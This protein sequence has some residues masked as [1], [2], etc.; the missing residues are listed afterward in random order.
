[1]LQN[2]EQEENRNESSKNI[3]I[4]CEGEGESLSSSILD[5]PNQNSRP[6][7]MVFKK[8][9]TIIPA[10][11]V[12]EAISTLH[13]LDLRWSGPI[14]PTEMQYVQQYIF[15]KYPEYNNGLVEDQTEKLDL[16]NLCIT[17]GSPESISDDH[18]RKSPT[19]AHHPTTTHMIKIQLE[20]S[21]LLDIFTKK[22]SPK[23]NFISI[24][25]I[26][27][28][29]GALQ[30]CG[31]TED[32][33]LVIFSPSVR[34]AMMMVGESYPFFKGNY[35]LTI[36]DEE[37]D[38]IREFVSFKDSKLIAAPSTWLDLRIKGSQLSQYFRRKCK[39]SP[40]GLFAYPACTNGGR[41]S[42]HW[43][44]EAHR[45]AWHVLLDATGLDLSKDRLGLALHQ[46]DFVLCTV[47]IMHAHPS[48]ITCLLVR[49][50]SFHTMDA[51]SS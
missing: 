40:K 6:T 41:S 24:P 42:M 2:I 30:K 50:N 16:Y 27:A 46:P 31:L 25:E 35:Y 17:H 32:E 1:M 11:L 38:V 34:E 18:R 51:S 9:N 43:M 45:N 8:V 36:L 21:K 48:D 26:Q 28:R 4:K 14:T 33:Y 44:S 12:A 49:K 23:S 5:S 29:N 10:H 15:A 47:N 7:S 13:G 37:G 19:T 22:I 3:A 20:P 39:N